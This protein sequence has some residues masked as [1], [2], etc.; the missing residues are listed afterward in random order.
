M[1]CL[2]GDG[3]ISL[4]VNDLPENIRSSVRLFADDCVLYRNIESPI[5]CQILQDDLNSLAQWEAD[6]Q[7]KFIV[8]KCHSMR[9]TRHPPDKHMQFGYTLNPLR[10]CQPDPYFAGITCHLLSFINC[11]SQ[12]CNF[13]NACCFSNRQAFSSR[14]PMLFYQLC[15]RVSCKRQKSR[16]P[17]DNCKQ[18]TCHPFRTG[19]LCI[20]HPSKL[21]AGKGERIR[22]LTPL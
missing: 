21:A 4:F 3:P 22:G 12:L 5:G 7:M 2:L 20:S 10:N 1:F 15:V 19:T 18:V 9:V 13:L 8:A 11:I 17:D 16:K 6:W 14:W